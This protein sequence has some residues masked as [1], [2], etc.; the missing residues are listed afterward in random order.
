MMFSEVQIQLLTKQKRY[1]DFINM[2]RISQGK[3]LYLCNQKPSQTYKVYVGKGNNQA[4]I[5]SAF[6]SRYWWHVNEDKST[7]EVNFY[8]QQLRNDEVIQRIRD[9]NKTI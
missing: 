7:P 5:K 4:L 3:P 1:I 9:G 2:V 8:W 6:R